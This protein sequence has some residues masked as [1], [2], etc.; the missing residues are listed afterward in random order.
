MEH[1]ILIFIY[2]SSRNVISKLPN[3][4]TRMFELKKFGIIGV[5]C[6]LFAEKKAF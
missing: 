4:E 3:F 1:F 5:T 2:T 6:N